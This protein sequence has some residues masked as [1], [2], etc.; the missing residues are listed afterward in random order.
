MPSVPK[1]ELN[2]DMM[3]DVTQKTVR[4]TIAIEAEGYCCDGEMLVDVLQDECW[5]VR[6]AVVQALGM[7]S[8]NRA[9]ASL[10]Y[11]AENDE[12]ERVRNLAVVML[13]WMKRLGLRE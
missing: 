8:D 11:A 7:M 9:W 12:N 1:Y 4:E 3:R 2:A 10:E 5:Q 6:C 13:R